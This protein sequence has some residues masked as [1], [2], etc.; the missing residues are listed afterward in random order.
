VAY[1]YP[2]LGL[3]VLWRDGYYAPAISGRD[4]TTSAASATILDSPATITAIS[5]VITAAATAAASTAPPACD[6]AHTAT[7]SASITAP[8]PAPVSPAISA[9]RSS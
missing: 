7:V 8:R 2:V 6:A 9:T 3:C 1:G 4:A 5:T